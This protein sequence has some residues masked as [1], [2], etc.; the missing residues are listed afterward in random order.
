MRK[1]RIG[2]RQPAQQSRNSHRHQ[3]PFGPAADTRRCDAGGI[4]PAAK[5]PPLK[6]R[7][8]MTSTEQPIPTRH[9]SLLAAWREFRWQ[10]RPWKYWHMPSPLTSSSFELELNLVGGHRLS[11]AG[12]GGLGCHPPCLQQ[13]KPWNSS[14]PRSRPPAVKM[15]SWA[16][17]QRNGNLKDTAAEKIEKKNMKRHPEGTPPF[18]KVWT[19]WN[20]L[21]TDIHDTPNKCQPESVRG[22]PLLVAKCWSPCRRTQAQGRD[23]SRVSSGADTHGGNHPSVWDDW[24]GCHA[25]LPENLDQSIWI[26]FSHNVSVLKDAYSMPRVSNGLCSGILELCREFVFV[27]WCSDVLPRQDFLEFRDLE[28]DCWIWQ[29][30]LALHLSFS[31]GIARCLADSP[32]SFQLRCQGAA[33]RIPA[34]RKMRKMRKMRQN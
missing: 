11:A 33:W 18:K 1:N 20:V 22:A 3:R 4:D 5:F 30:C 7:R 23:T 19:V 29:Q 16:G 28:E 34:R 6:L 9:L 32:H 21:N 25:L 24:S 17:P 27:Q 26:G 14:D 31:V 10:W 15:N 13:R 8:K 12:S 2:K